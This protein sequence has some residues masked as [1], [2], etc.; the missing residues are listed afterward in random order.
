MEL[1]CEG[2]SRELQKLERELVHDG[3]L[4]GLNRE[5]IMRRGGIWAELQE[6]I[7]QK[8]IDLVVIGRMAGVALK[9]Y[10]WG[11]SPNKSFDTPTTPL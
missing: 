10:F 2:A 11:P 4:D 1:G 8:Q 6:I 3:S 9:S 7:F 5:F